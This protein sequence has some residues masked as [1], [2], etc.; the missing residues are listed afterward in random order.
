[1]SIAVELTGL[2][3]SDT[4]ELIRVTNA[5]LVKV[6]AGVENASASTSEQE[7]NGQLVA[8]QENGKIE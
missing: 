6:N 7:H 5:A 4:D 1:M 2:S 3:D 8:A